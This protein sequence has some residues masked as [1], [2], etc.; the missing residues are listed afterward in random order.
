MIIAGYGPAWIGHFVYEKN[1]PTTL[2]YP[3]YSLMA[4]FVMF[5]EVVRGQRKIF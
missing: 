4:D 2:A 5:W 1:Q 3:I